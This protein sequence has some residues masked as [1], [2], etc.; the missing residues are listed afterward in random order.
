MSRAV[1]QATPE[2][3]VTP[4]PRVWRTP[5]IVD[6]PKLT[7]LTLA[8]EIGGGGGTGGGGSTVFGWLLVAGLALGAGACSSDRE[9]GGEP[10]ESPLPAGQLVTCV[11]DRATL[12]IGC[13]SPEAAPGT[14]ILGGQGKRVA[15]RSS[16]V[17]YN[18]GSGILSADVTVQNLSA[19]AIGTLDGVT[20][21]LEGIR[22]FFVSGPNALP[23]GTVTVNNPTGLAIFTSGQTPYYE[24]TNVM[25]APQAITAPMTWE[26][27]FAGG[28]TSFTFSVLVSTNVPSLTA[29]RR[30]QEEPELNQTNWQGVSGW[31][32]D[33]LAL[34]GQYGEVAIRDSGRWTSRVDPSGNEASRGGVAGGPNDVTTLTG[35]FSTRRWDGI[36]WRAI[37]GLSGGPGDGGLVSFVGK[38]GTAGPGACAFGFVIRCFDGS[39]WSSIALPGGVNKAAA[40]TVIDGNLVILTDQGRVWSRDSSTGTWTQIGGAGGS[41]QTQGPGIIFGNSLTSLW[42]ISTVNN[43]DPVIRY[44]DG[45]SWS[46]Q[47]VPSG[48][49]NNTGIPAGGVAFEWYEAYI[50]RPDFV[51]HG[52]V[53]QWNG[54]N[55]TDVYTESFNFTGIW[56]RSNEEIYVSAAGGRI[57]G[58]T[59]DGWGFV[60][61]AP[62]RGRS[63][64]VTDDNFVFVGGEGGS[65][66]RYNG[67]IWEQV[68]LTGG[69]IKSIF[70]PDTTNVAMAHGTAALWRYDGTSWVATSPSAYA[71]HGTG[72]SGSHDIWYVGQYGQIYHVDPGVSA[73]L[74]ME[75]GDFG[76]L[77]DLYAVWAHSTTF[78]VAVGQ[79]GAIRMWNGTAW[80]V[81]ASPTGNALRAVTGPSP[82]DVWAVG[83]GGVIVH[84]DGTDWTTVASGTGQDLNGV[85]AASASEVYAVGLNK[86]LLMYNGVSWSPVAVPSTIPGLGF[87]GVHGLTGGQAF[88]AGDR[89]FRGLR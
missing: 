17:S 37:E 55:W 1:P 40:S 50:V 41:G 46:T 30:W 2:S 85:W 35:A 64:W 83:D 66:Y 26:F 31:G 20:P 21:N 89:S 47:A 73:E 27:L 58:K 13:R 5:T 86:T 49:E 18:G 71:W 12:S 79:G 43:S 3:P 24:W 76:P 48:Q 70:A 11:A 28:A 15:F 19:T 81:A 44:W 74:T 72:G 10:G 34:F 42:T 67:T 25:L 75:A 68:H 36:S 33:G 62:E 65:V 60:Q 23:S 63:T 45:A 57:V 6:L 54:T 22:V 69:P 14:I 59:V 61:A 9:L 88:I 39:A 38:K 78:A 51:G 84:Y 4:A 16:N 8:S 77:D 29:I 56:A 80:S 53:W 82:T 52:H 7:S 87:Y 32:S